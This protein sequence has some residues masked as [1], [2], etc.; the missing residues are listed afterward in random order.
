METRLVSGKGKE[1]WE[2]CGFSKGWKIPRVGLSGGII[3]AW[4]PRQDLR[5]VFDSKNL[6]HINLLDDRD[7]SLFI[8]CVYGHPDHSNRGMVWQ[9]LKSLQ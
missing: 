4:L 2:K 7:I 6:A 9:Q 5:V 8:T 1:L 3:L